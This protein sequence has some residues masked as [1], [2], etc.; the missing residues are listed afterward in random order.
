MALVGR[1][2]MVGNPTLAV[3]G[4]EEAGGFNAILAGFQGQRQW[5]GLPAE[6]MSFW[7]RSSTPTFDW[8]GPRPPMIMATEN[9]SLN[10]RRCC[11]SSAHDPPQIFS[12]VRT[13]WSPEAVKRV[14]GQPRASP[15]GHHRPAQLGRYRPG[16]LGQG[17]QGRRASDQ[18][19]V[20]DDPLRTSR[21]VLMR[22]PSTPPTRT[23]S[24]VEGSPRTS[25]A[26]GACS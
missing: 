2:L 9:D 3:K 21:P 15:P 26:K 10:A 17:P 7:K 25:S 22:P 12:D 19:V 8:T 6:Q 23:T 11:S 18:A 24:V 20:G 5:I 1:D 4:F 16:R 13:Y 14:T